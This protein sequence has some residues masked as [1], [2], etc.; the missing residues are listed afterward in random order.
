MYS[1]NTIREAVFRTIE[2]VNELLPPEQALDARDDLVLVGPNAALDSMGF[3]NF[4]V[5][6][7]EELESQLGKPLNI[8]DLLLIQTDDGTLVSTVSD[9]VTVLSHR[10][11]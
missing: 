2:Q 10:L 8:S 1:P 9:L 7:E 5:A 11:E 4:V 3:V 6:L